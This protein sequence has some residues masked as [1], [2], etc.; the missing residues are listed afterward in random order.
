MRRGVC[1]GRQGSG[2][3]KPRGVEEKPDHCAW[4]MSGKEIPPSLLFSPLRLGK[5]LLWA[6]FIFLAIVFLNQSWFDMLF[7]DF[8]DVLH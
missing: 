1:A 2:C 7:F 5:V 6:P 4:L 8:V 3:N